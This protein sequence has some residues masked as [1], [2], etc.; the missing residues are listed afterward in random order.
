MDFWVVIKWNQGCVIL[1]Y[2]GNPWKFGSWVTLAMIESL[3]FVT[4]MFWYIWCNGER[5]WTNVLSPA[6]V[7][8]SKR[9]VWVLSLSEKAN[10]DGIFLESDEDMGG[11]VSGL[12]GCENWLCL[13]Y[14]LLAHI[15]V[16]HDPKDYGKLSK[17]QLALTS[18]LI[19]QKV[20]KGTDPYS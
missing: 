18:H 20:I 17:D 16:L 12:E 7:I 19:N 5:T 2:C 6:L 4:A 8:S 1:S 3:T 14:T 9:K 13:P 15:W 10:C 11:F